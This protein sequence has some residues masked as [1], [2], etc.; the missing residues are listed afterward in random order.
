[1]SISKKSNSQKDQ[2]QQTKHK[3][4]N[5]LYITK[6]F[7]MLEP[8][9]PLSPDI[10]GITPVL[11]HAEEISK[12]QSVERILSR[13][14]SFDN[15]ETK[16]RY[17][18]V[19]DNLRQ[20][21][22]RDT[23]I[24]QKIGD[25]HDLLLFIEKKQKNDIHSQIK[26]KVEEITQERIKNALT[27]KGAL[28][29]GREISK[30]KS[31]IAEIDGLQK[32]KIEPEVFAQNYSRFLREIN[33]AERIIEQYQKL[34]QNLTE[35]NNSLSQQIT[36]LEQEVIILKNQLQIAKT[37]QDQS[38][39]QIE[40][41]KLTQNTNQ[42]SQSSSKSSSN[43]DP[44]AEA[45]TE[46][47]DPN[48]MINTMRA[49]LARM[50]SFMELKNYWE[51]YTEAVLDYQKDYPGENPNPTPAQIAELFLDAI[52]NKQNNQY[53]IGINGFH[54][55]QLKD[56]FVS[57]TEGKITDFKYN[58]F[59]NLTTAP[60]TSTNSIP[61][62]TITTSAINPQNTTPSTTPNP[63]NTDPNLQNQNPQNET[64][65]TSALWQAKLD[66]E[67]IISQA[68]VQQRFFKRK[69]NEH[70]SLSKHE[71]EEYFD[72]LLA[73]LAELETR[74]PNI[75]NIGNTKDSGKNSDKERST[76]IATIQTTRNRIEQYNKEAIETLEKSSPIKII[77]GFEAYLDKTISALDTIKNQVTEA[78]KDQDLPGSTKNLSPSQILSFTNRYKIESAKLKNTLREVL[79]YQQKVEPTATSEEKELISNFITRLREYLGNNSIYTSQGSQNTGIIETYI[80]DLSKPEPSTKTVVATLNKVTTGISEISKQIEEIAKGVQTAWKDTTSTT[81][82]TKK[83][84]LDADDIVNLTQRYDLGVLSLAQ[85]L[86]EINSL[87]NNMTRLN[88]QKPVV[89]A[90]GATENDLNK[91]EAYNILLQKVMNVKNVIEKKISDTEKAKDGLSK[92]NFDSKIAQLETKQKSLIE[93]FAKII[94]NF[95]KI[96]GFMEKTSESK[97]EGWF[98]KKMEQIFLSPHT[99][100]DTEQ[101]LSL[102]E[103]RE[104]L[105][106]SFLENLYKNIE[107]METFGQDLIHNVAQLETKK[108]IELR[109]KMIAMKNK[110]RE[111]RNKM[112][113][114]RSDKLWA[115]LRGVIKNPKLIT[116]LFARKV[117]RSFNSLINGIEDTSN[118]IDKQQRLEALHGILNNGVLKGGVALAAGITLGP[119][120]SLGSLAALSLGSKKVGEAKKVAEANAAA[121]LAV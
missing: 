71:I 23:L 67:K 15:T 90:N 38:Q 34:K 83:S 33:H 7:I 50:K 61:I 26:A 70:K 30:V 17:E 8:R 51:A 31:N 117:S 20:R 81:P 53:K 24:Q 115:Y 78:K 11:K 55:D 66:L 91:W 56:Y 44:L 3:S 49:E 101:F 40:Q 18:K 68:N 42:A 109:K 60:T 104:E 52:L 86:S 80:R 27:H 65:K 2:K 99:W 10:K 114:H 48:Y 89:G 58:I 46:T 77:A 87:I 93:D 9:Q 63:K 13:K 62:S 45:N 39:T 120:F 94:T 102:Y 28:L 21:S 97:R 112:Y 98:G 6:F 47:K 119:V 54:A 59:D 14:V 82:D 111:L 110:A 22:G 5:Y 32:N 107:D 16:K 100:E 36:T 4:A 73:D 95:G 69:I 72:S 108:Y 12:P 113:A 43:L 121:A 29:V 76:L 1:M 64:M 74:V 35:Q 19:L 106:G 57:V 92:I 79:D 103:E 118:A 84:K 41:D 96:R 105:M 88:G 25:I 75:S 85:S 37:N 116:A